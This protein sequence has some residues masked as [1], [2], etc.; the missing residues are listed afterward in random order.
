MLDG[1]MDP[2]SPAMG[3]LIA[4]ARR[5]LAKRAPGAVVDYGRFHD[6]VDGLLPNGDDIWG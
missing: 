2:R 4:D 6:L 1:S 3:R 5:L